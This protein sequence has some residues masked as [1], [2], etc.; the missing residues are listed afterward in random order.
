[1][2]SEVAER[3]GRPDDRRCR[4]LWSADKKQ[5]MLAVAMTMHSTEI[6]QMEASVRLR[7]PL[8]AANGTTA[9][10]PRVASL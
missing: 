1:M 2:M 6:L 5:V 10:S 4:R 8:L 9:A 3:S 7:S